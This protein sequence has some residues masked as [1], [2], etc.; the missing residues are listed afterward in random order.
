MGFMLA[1]LSFLS[2]SIPQVTLVGHDWGGALVW[3]M[4]RYY[5]ERIR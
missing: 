4:A 1:D 3:T 5:P 2:K